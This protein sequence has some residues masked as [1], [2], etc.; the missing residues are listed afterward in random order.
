MFLSCLR[1]AP[2]RT[3]EEFKSEQAQAIIDYLGIS[4]TPLAHRSKFAAY[5]IRRDAVNVQI[6]S[7]TVT[8][9][10]PALELPVRTH[11]HMRDAVAASNHRNQ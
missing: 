4:V 2:R 1:V 5:S 9:A 8:L 10:N 11:E 3:E 6:Q 7:P